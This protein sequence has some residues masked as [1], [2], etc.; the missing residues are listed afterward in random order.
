MELKSEQA[1]PI[2]IIWWIINNLKDYFNKE[3]IK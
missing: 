3:I 2:I 1:P